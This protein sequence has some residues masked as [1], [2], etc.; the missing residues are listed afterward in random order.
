MNGKLIFEASPVATDFGG[1][2]ALQMELNPTDAVLHFYRNNAQILNVSRFVS[3]KL[4]E[5]NISE[6][7]GVE[8]RANENVQLKES[9]TSYSMSFFSGSRL[10]TKEEQEKF[11]AHKRKKFKKFRFDF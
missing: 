5:Y 11:E 2:I 9:W 3:N 4:D 8:E 1:G 6:T 10:F 7:T